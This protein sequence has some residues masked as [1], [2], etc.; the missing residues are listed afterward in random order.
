VTGRTIDGEMG[1][2]TGVSGANNICELI[3]ELL[4]E[5][6]FGLNGGKLKKVIA[7]AQAALTVYTELAFPKQ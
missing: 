3:W 7:A 4:T 5:T 6:E 2:R 1:G